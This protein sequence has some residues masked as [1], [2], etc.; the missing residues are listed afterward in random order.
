MAYHNI[1]RISGNHGIKAEDYDPLLDYLVKNDCPF[2]KIMFFQQTG[3][4]AARHTDE[5]KRNISVLKTVMEKY[6]KTLGVKAGLNIICT[7]GFMSQNVDP[8]LADYDKRTYEDGSIEEGALCPSSPKTVEFITTLYSEAAKANPDFIYVD[9]DVCGSYC[10]CPRC[11][12][13]YK[14]HFSDKNLSEAEERIERKHFVIA[15]ILKIARKAVDSVNPAIPMGFMCSEFGSLGTDYSDF[16]EILHNDQGE[17]YCRPGGGNWWEDVDELMLKL[18][19]VGRETAA[20]KGKASEIHAEIENHPRCVLQKSPDLMS[21]ESLCYLSAGCNGIAHN[22]LS[23]GSEFEEYTSW[24]EGVQ[25]TN[26]FAKLLAEKFENYRRIGIGAYFNNYPTTQA[27]KFV[28]KKWDVYCAEYPEQF[29]LLGLPAAYANDDCVCYT[30]SLNLVKSL[31]DNEITELLSKPVMM[32]G[33]TLNY[34]N[35]RGYGKLTGFQAHLSSTDMQE[36]TLPHALNNQTVHT[37]NAHTHFGWAGDSYTIEKTNKD[38]FYLTELITFQNEFLG[39][40]SGIYQNEL[41]GKIYVGGYSMYPISEG[42]SRSEDVKRIVRYLSDEKLPAYV[43][44]YHRSLLWARTENERTTGAI[45]ANVAL[46]KNKNLCI[47]LKTDKTQ[48]KLYQNVDGAIKETI[49]SATGKDGA[50]TLFTLPTI[51]ALELCFIE[52]M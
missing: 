12:E 22:F 36:R 17:S 21:F 31:T 9:D 24:I 49:L 6:R 23:A 11:L 50:Y 32:D 18:H 20:L 48:M 39:Y 26:A 30:S 5:S 7:V 4:H 25:Q 44:S 15:N 45:L 16:A 19:K 51:N 8:R 43:Y 13:I 40:G 38:A 46:G 29:Y 34:L 28:K 47:A 3:G 41:G 1:L 52:E 27:T 35:E 37:R 42:K 10:H 2:D 33:E 14:K